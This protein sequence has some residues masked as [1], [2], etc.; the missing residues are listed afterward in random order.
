MKKIGYRAMYWLFVLTILVYSKPGYAQ[1]GQGTIQGIVL[2]AQT[3]DPLPGANIVLEGTTQGTITDLDGRYDFSVPSGTY[4]LVASF[5]G[6]RNLTQ[7]FT[8]SAGGA[9]D[10][11]FNLQPDNLQ[12]DEVVVTGSGGLPTSKLRLGNSISVVDAA[13]LDAVAVPDMTRL[14][15]SRVPGVQILNSSGVLGANSIVQLRGIG[16]L[17]GNV[18]PLIYV[19]GVR[20]SNFNS[21]E[22]GTIDG[23]GGQA[24]STLNLINPADID[25]VEVL[26]G[27]SAATL[28][29]SDAA[30][31]VIQIFT[32]SGDS[33]RQGRP[34]A[35]SFT[36]SLTSYDW[37]LYDDQLSDAAQDYLRSGSGV[38]TIQQLSAGG[39]GARFDFYS[40]LTYR[41][42]NV[43]IRWSDQD[44]FDVKS[45]FNYRPDS[46]ST[47]NFGAS[48]TQ[49]QVIRPDADNSGRQFSGWRS[50]LLKPNG[51][52]GEYSF[53]LGTDETG[54]EIE[55]VRN[56]FSGET[57]YDDDV[58]D[59]VNNEYDNRRYSGNI[60]YNRKLT[61]K[62]GLN[63]Q[64]G[65][66]DM[67][68]DQLR[69]IEQGHATDGD[70]FRRNDTRTLKA[71]N[72][73]VILTGQ[74]NL[75]E[76]IGAAVSAGADYYEQKSNFASVGAT[77]FEPGFDGSSQFGDSDT[78]SISESASVFS[79]GAVFGQ[80]QFDFYNRAFVT[81][82]IRADRSSSFGSEAS[83]RVYPKASISYLLPVEENIPALSVAKI[84]AS[85]GQAGI[86]PDPG[87][88][89][90]ALLR[91]ANLDDLSAVIIERPGNDDLKPS[92]TTE[93]EAGLDLAFFEGRVG[94]EF[95]Y[96][97]QRVRDDIF[98]VFTKP[99]DGFGNRVQAFNLGEI[100]AK[101]IELSFYATPVVSQNFHYTTRVNLSTIETEVIDDGGFPFSGGPFN[102][103]RYFR[104]EEGMPLGVFHYNQTQIDEFGNASTSPNTEYFG[105]I[106][107]DFTGNWFHSFTFAKRL[108]LTANF[109]WAKNF[110]LLN[111]S[112]V[113][114]F[115]NGVFDDDFTE[116]QYAA[117]REAL[118]L[119]SEDRTPEQIAALTHYELHTE[120]RSPVFLEDGDFFK[121]RELALSY[122]VPREFLTKV[123]IQGLTFT[124][125]ATNVFTITGYKGFDPEVSVGGGS[126]LHRG[127]DNRS[128]PPPRRLVFRANFRF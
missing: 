32:K 103:L 10:L 45:N 100:E 76:E 98:S 16:S 15:E 122:N 71:F 20:M 24:V 46:K 127:S 9:A 52:N 29:G 82:G 121:L 42:E 56:P 92:R 75:A 31:G 64:A 11:N 33:F 109:G 55:V 48:Y 74:F 44:F 113:N 116:E 35:L 110:Q 41:S 27:A 107:P 83:A 69:W 119:A 67:T 88:A 21:F 17:T 112:R 87:A 57:L 120:S 13:E 2:D 117:G 114:M 85:F 14:L 118:A 99:S 66:E 94:A 111:F 7:S 47:L 102:S 128:L 1:D 90:L 125:S 126:I 96:Y 80:G 59:K 106:T 73:S 5:I 6:Y 84:R 12:L 124:A 37:S 18:A 8:V 79:S 3:G 63:A 51:F 30:N 38:G 105:N 54:S 26:K 49:D 101:G 36:S 81:L 50:N 115:R 95:T 61:S 62:I 19:D 53:D 23:R 25:R 91:V 77:S 43:G 60:G 39:G 104:I 70:G 22:S 65:Y 58:F 28:Y 86:Q 97:N 68:L 93:I 108:N 78:Y 4:N 89:D 34:L 40:S 72:G 123:G